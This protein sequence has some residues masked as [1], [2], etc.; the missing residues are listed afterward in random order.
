[1]KKENGAPYSS[2]IQKLRKDMSG[3]KLKKIKNDNSAL[4]RQQKLNFGHFLK[5]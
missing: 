3:K 1:M 2:E 5:I 4:M